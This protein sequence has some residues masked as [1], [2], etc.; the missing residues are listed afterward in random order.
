MSTNDSTISQLAADIVARAVTA[1]EAE[2][3]TGPWFAPAD[4]I[5]RGWSAPG[6]IDAELALVCERF[7]CSEAEWF[8]DH[9]RFSTPRAELC[10]DTVRD[11]LT[12]A[13]SALWGAHV[14][15]L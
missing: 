15:S 11:A 7:G 4:A 1:A 8:T 6:L 3:K 13:V 2:S 5:M 12:A 10:G 9:D 14:A